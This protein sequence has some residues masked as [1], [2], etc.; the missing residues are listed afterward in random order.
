M[1][2][3]NHPTW[4]LTIGLLMS[5]LIGLGLLPAAA[6]AAPRALAASAAA[7]TDL[8]LGRPATASGIRAGY[9]AAQVTDGSR[10]TPW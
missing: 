4:R 1:T 3:R 10:Q 6:H 2:R 9:P 8:A 5:A 7:E